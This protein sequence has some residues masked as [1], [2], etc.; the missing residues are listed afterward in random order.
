MEHQGT[1]ENN[2]TCAEFSYNNIYRESPEMAPFEVLY[3]CRCHTPLNWIEL[4]EKVI[5]G[6]DLIDEAEA[7]SY[8]R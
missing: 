1:W 4:G 3:G 2:L 6:P 5:F 8:P 7:L